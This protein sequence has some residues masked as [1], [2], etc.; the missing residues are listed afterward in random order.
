VE[1]IA[2]RSDATV[3]LVNVVYSLAA[4]MAGHFAIETFK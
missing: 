4:Q 2:P 3:K 1:A